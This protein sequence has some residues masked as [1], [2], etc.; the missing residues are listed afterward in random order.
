M[1]QA[2][3]IRITQRYFP[4]SDA[5]QIHQNG[6]P[7]TASSKG[8]EVVLRVRENC[9]AP[10]CSEI[11]SG[12]HYAAIGLTF[13][14]KVLIDYDGVFFLPSEVGEMLKDADYEVPKECFT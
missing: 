1:N 14:G 10:H 6:S 2:S 5:T 3:K 8:V 9:I 11:I 4:Q 7:L 12:E 13:D